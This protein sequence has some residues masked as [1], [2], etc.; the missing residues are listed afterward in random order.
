MKFLDIK[1]KVNSWLIETELL[2]DSEFQFTIPSDSSDDLY[3]DGIHNNVNILTYSTLKKMIKDIYTEDSKIMTIHKAKGLEF[4]KVIVGIEPFSRNERYIN[5]LD[6][7]SSPNVLPKEEDENT[8]KSEIAEYT[9]IIYVGISRA[10]NE[11]TLYIKINESDKEEF[12]N[13][14]DTSLKNFMNK[15]HISEPFYEFIER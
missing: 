4:K 6:V 12:K 5:K 8:K 3:F 15:N 11:L 2:R 7:L 14:F 13:K 9:R 10:I 1:N